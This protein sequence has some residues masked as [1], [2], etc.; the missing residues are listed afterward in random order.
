MLVVA[1]GI[2][3]FGF[4]ILQGRIHLTERAMAVSWAS[5]HRLPRTTRVWWW[6]YTP[7]ALKAT[8]NGRLICQKPKD[9]GDTYTDLGSHLRQSPSDM[10]HL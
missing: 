4:W 7:G 9:E 10:D 2:M 1:H 3:G 5:G 8:R 6:S